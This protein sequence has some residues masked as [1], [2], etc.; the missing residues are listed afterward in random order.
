[1]QAKITPIPFCGHMRYNNS[2]IHDDEEEYA[3]QASSESRRVV[4]AGDDMRG[5]GLRSDRSERKPR[6]AAVEAIRTGG[7]SPP[8]TG[9]GYRG[10]PWVK[11]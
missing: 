4:Q 1:M 2:H 8:L 5:S 6:I 9:A 10:G 7:M 11:G 3:D